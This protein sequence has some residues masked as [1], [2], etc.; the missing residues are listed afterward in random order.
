MAAKKEEESALA[1]G[2]IPQGEKE[3]PAAVAVVT[4]PADTDRQEVD[5]AP[6]PKPQPEAAEADAEEEEDDE[7]GET[8]EQADEAEEKKPTW[9]AKL[10][11]KIDKVE[12]MLQGEINR[13]DKLQGKKSSPKQKS[14]RRRLT[15]F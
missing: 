14:K 9:A 7:E 13:T 4:S 6:A 10:E 5:L 1:G 12:R 15:L 11:A 3:K 2:D 8:E